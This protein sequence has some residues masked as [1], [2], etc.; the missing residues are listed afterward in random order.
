MSALNDALATF[1]VSAR[2]TLTQKII[3]AV[4]EA[5]V[6]GEQHG[7]AHLLKHL[8]AYVLDARDTERTVAAA[9]KARIEADTT[10]RIT[11]VLDG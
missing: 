11:R 1:S 6:A 3:D 4:T 2:L 10:E 7:E 9:W 8:D 5:F